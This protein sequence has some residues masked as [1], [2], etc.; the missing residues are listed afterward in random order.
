MVHRGPVEKRGKE[1]TPRTKERT[2]NEGRPPPQ[3]PGAPAPTAT[4]ICPPKTAIFGRNYGGIKV[5]SGSFWGGKHQFGKIFRKNGDFKPLAKNSITPNNAV[6]HPQKIPYSS[7]HYSK[8]FLTHTIPHHPQSK[9]F[10][11][12][13]KTVT[14]R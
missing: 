6:Q 11:H 4:R 5:F 8:N 12:F 7:N 9:I 2:A 13:I 3:E 1:G 14:S 10:Y